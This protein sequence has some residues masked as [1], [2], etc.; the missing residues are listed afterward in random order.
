MSC[1]P[2]VPDI[3]RSA[4]ASP[5]ITTPLSPRFPHHESLRDLFA[6]LWGSDV[7]HLWLAVLLFRF[8]GVPRRKSVSLG[9]DIFCN[10]APVSVF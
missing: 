7:E 8:P 3:I 2:G 6:L 5:F 9:T 1:S 10:S 4:R